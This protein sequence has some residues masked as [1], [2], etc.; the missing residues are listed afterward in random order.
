MDNLSG[1]SI[2]AVAGIWSI[3]FIGYYVW[4][5]WSLSRLFPKIGLPSWAGWVPLWNQWQLIQRGGLPG[6]LVLLGLIPFLGIVVLVVMIIAINR[7]NSEHGKGAGFTVLGIVLPP[8]WAMLLANHIGDAA[9]ASPG[10]RPAQPVASGIPGFGPPADQ[11][12][13]GWQGLPPVPPQAI[14]PQQPAQPQHVVPQQPPHQ[15]APGFAPQPAQYQQP[16]QPQQPQFVQPPQPVQPV[17]Q[18]QQP[19]QPLTPQQQLWAEPARQQVPP[20]PPAAA[21]P[22]PGQSFGFSNTTEGAFERL[23]AE[24]AQRT[25]ASPL[26][27]AEAQRPFSWPSADIAENADFD[28]RSPVVLPDPQQAPAPAAAPAPANAP[29]PVHAPAPA[30]AAAPPVP[31]VAAQS[32]APTADPAPAAP[33]PAA[34]AATAAPAAPIPNPAAELSDDDAPS[35]FDTGSARQSRTAPR[36]SEH[37]A[38]EAAGLVAGAAGA[39]AAVAGAALA[40]A[41]A[42]QASNDAAPETAPPAH[43]EEFD[44]TVVV[45]RRTRWGLELPDGD[46]LEL[47]GDDVVLGRKPD[48]PEG[49]TAL[50]IVDPTRTM[51]KTH[52]RLRREGETWTIED[53]QSTNGVAIIDDLGQASQIDAGLP[54]PAT[55]R[56]VI[57]T[58]EVKLQPIT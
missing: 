43:D 18:P 23:A 35:I 8:L 6:W 3:V 46:V 53:L 19:A 32:A 42:A 1:S 31:P 12:G 38:A 58:L 52:A 22:A 16:V 39:G 29:E 5:L 37:D 26:G 47:L 54:V 24:E 57:G 13:G 34:P 21:P 55:D 25:G 40:G 45:V 4:Y 28:S 50:Q 51:S 2:L 49:S 36:T 30:A 7:I 11:H 9:Y 44:R 41:A 20:A 56:L 27:A 14:Q 33:A 10:A 48:A 15:S 17:A